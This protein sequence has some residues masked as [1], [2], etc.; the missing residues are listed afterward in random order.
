MILHFDFA[1]DI[2]Q[3]LKLCEELVENARFQKVPVPGEFFLEGIFPLLVAA[4]FLFAKIIS[5]SMFEFFEVALS[6]FPF[7]KSETLNVIKKK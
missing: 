1:E 4:D 6:V 2:V 3:K 5:F 7:A